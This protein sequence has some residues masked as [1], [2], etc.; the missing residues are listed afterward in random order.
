MNRARMQIP[1]RNIVIVSIK[2][3]DKF[4]DFAIMVCFASKSIQ[5]SHD[6]MEDPIV[7]K[8]SPGYR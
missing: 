5:S 4:A 7:Q 8:K 6:L 1:D 2:S 3:R